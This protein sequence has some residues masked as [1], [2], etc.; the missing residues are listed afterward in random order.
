MNS[1]CLYIILSYHCKYWLIFFWQGTPSREHDGDAIAA[2]IDAA[3][4]SI[5]VEVMGI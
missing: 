2:N 1:V 4:V 5:S 3:T